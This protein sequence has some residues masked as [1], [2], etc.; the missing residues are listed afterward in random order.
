MAWEGG[1]GGDEY[2]HIFYPFFIFG[3]FYSFFGY[4]LRVIICSLFK[5]NCE[6]GHIA[7]RYTPKKFDLPF[8][9][10]QQIYLV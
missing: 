4:F 9:F 7:L 5:L 3:Y 2:L 6:S 10:P 8:K 1:V